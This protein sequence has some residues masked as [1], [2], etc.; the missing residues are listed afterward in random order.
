MFLLLLLRSFRSHWFSASSQCCDA[1]ID[2]CRWCCES[3][4]Y[5]KTSNSFF[6]GEK[7]LYFQISAVVE[8]LNL[9]W[10]RSVGDQSNS[11]SSALCMCTCTFKWNR[12]STVLRK[13]I[14]Y[15]MHP[16]FKCLTYYLAHTAHLYLNQLTQTAVWFPI[17]RIQNNCLEITIKLRFRWTLFVVL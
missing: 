13:H 1:L 6:C 15:W 12:N 5:F 8:E 14:P 11:S 17:L 16:F 9:T 10:R 7:L 3:V 4:N 2:F